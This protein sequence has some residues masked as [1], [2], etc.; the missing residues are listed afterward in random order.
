MSVATIDPV[1]NRVFS[2]YSNLFSQFLGPIAAPPNS[3]PHDA[4]N[5]EKWTLNETL[6]GK[7]AYLADT[8]LDLA[9]T[10][11][12]TWHTD[13]ILPMKE[14]LDHH[15]KWDVVERG[16]H[17]MGPTP[18][19]GASRLLTERRSQQ[20][21]SLVRLGL[22]FEFEH[23]FIRTAKG[24]AGFLASLAQMARSVQVTLGVEVIRSLS[25][26]FRK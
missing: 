6:R 5:R 18:E 9:L 3:D 21:A 8:V 7:N 20:S 1:S 13:V 22:A 11:N 26:S 15:F 23:D 2:G 14:T 25:G 10:A 16:T 24:R 4:R 19:L 12:Q 17:L